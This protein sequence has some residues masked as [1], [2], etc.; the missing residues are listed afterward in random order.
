M[1]HKGFSLS[2][3]PLTS[4]TTNVA[5][6]G[7]LNSCMDGFQKPSG[8]IDEIDPIKFIHKHN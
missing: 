1:E 6:S 8:D 4:H 2:I 3:A 7:I 5:E